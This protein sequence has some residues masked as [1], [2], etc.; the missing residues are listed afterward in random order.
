MVVNK[1]SKGNRKKK[2]MTRNIFFT[3]F[4]GFIGRKIAQTLFQQ[5]KDTHFQFLVQ[6]RYKQTAIEEIEK[7][8][9]ELSGFKDNSIILTGDLVQPDLG[10][11]ASTV[12]S[13]AGTIDEIWHLAAI[14]DIEVPEQLAYEVNV[15]GTVRLLELCRQM[16]KMEKFIFFST[17]VVSGKRQGLILED[18]LDV[19]QSFFNH[20]ESTKF[21]A[22]RLVR[23][24]G[25][26]TPTIIFRPSIVVGDSQ[27]GL[28]DKFDGPY[29]LMKLLS[30]LKPFADRFGRFAL[31]GVSSTSAF[32][33]IVPVDYV[34]KAACHIAGKPENLGKC[35]H[36]SSD[37]PVSFHDFLALIY[38]T[39][40]LGTPRGAMPFPLLEL[41]IKIPI[42]SKTLKIPAQLLPYMNHY[43]MFDNSN[44]RSALA[45]SKI[46]CPEPAEYF[47]RLINHLADAPN[48]DG[49]AMY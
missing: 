36:L 34:A 40:G 1:K 15:D 10:L 30:D 44:T 2:N 12:Q 49:Q 41:L 8:D 37:H 5:N 43:A 29:F 35:F 28:A 16:N 23:K 11:D 21:E 42:V 7:I 19:G 14:Y 26:D 45:G 25:K 3:G 6:D 38:S 17:S 24:N 13:L 31:P 4:P 33:N 18:E 9:L 27:S 39:L 20:Y 32:L 47:Y 46:R 22:E 48:G